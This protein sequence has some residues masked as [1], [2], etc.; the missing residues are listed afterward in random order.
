MLATER[1]NAIVTATRSRPP[2]NAL[3]GETR[4]RV[5]ASLDRSPARDPRRPR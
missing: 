4:R 1:A 2:V 3:D 5:A